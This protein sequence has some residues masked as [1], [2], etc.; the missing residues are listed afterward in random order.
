MSV[1]SV[2]K[3]TQYIIMINTA[4]ELVAFPQLHWQ[5]KEA[6]SSHNDRSADTFMVYTA[7]LPSTVLYCTAINFELNAE[8]VYL[9]I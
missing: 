7:G 1:R 8:P 4:N 2:S 9:N 6:F 5:T 3:V